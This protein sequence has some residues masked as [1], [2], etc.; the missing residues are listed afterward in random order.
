MAEVAFFVRLI[1]EI[2]SVGPEV[3][4]VRAEMRGVVLLGAALLHSSSR[5]AACI[6]PAGG[7]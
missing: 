5:G 1:V 7:E 3:H 2:Q 4:A 6:R